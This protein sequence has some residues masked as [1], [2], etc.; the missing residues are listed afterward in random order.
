MDG[1]S[2]WG[3]LTIVAE[4][5]VMVRSSLRTVTSRSM[6]WTCSTRSVSAAHGRSSR[7][8]PVTDKLSPSS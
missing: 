3:K 1:H 5:D 8:R 2:A 6:S 7:R 4:A